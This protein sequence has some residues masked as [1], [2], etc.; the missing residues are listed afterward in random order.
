MVTDRPRLLDS[1]EETPHAVADVSDHPAREGRDIGGTTGEGPEMRSKGVVRVVA[2]V[3]LSADLAQA[4]PRP[5]HGHRVDA[6]E[7]VPSDLLG[8]FHR[9][10]KEALAWDR[11][12]KRREDGKGVELGPL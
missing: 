5:E 10:E 7:R 6:Y 1:I 12:A 4:S 8:T 3:R 2:F 9:L 11:L